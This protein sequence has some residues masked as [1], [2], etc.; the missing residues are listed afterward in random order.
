MDEKKIAEEVAKTLDEVEKQ[1][2][3]KEAKEKAIG[4]LVAVV[5]F[6]IFFMYL[7][8]PSDPNSQSSASVCKGL[9]NAE[10]QKLIKDARWLKDNGYSR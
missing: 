2:S 10:C 6:V 9:T 3:E 7:L 5:L 4:F 8:S 1:K